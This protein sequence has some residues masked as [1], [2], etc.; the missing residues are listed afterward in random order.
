MSKPHKYSYCLTL[1]LEPNMESELENLAYNSRYS[2][3][4]VIRRAIRQTI[5]DSYQHDLQQNTFAIQGGAR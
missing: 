3:A 5:A 2:K 4:Y 1:R